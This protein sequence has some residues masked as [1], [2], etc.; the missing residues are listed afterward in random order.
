MKAPVL[1]SSSNFYPPRL[2]LFSDSLCRRSK[3]IIL[4]EMKNFLIFFL[5]FFNFF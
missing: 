3:L 4:V 2:N 1:K 5:H